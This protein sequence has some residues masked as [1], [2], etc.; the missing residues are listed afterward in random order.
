MR[1][2]WPIVPGAN[3]TFEAARSSAASEREIQSEGGFDIGQSGSLAGEP[4]DVPAGSPVASDVAAGVSPDAVPGSLDGDLD[5][6]PEP[7]SL[8][9]QP[10]PLKWTE[11]ATIALRIGLPH[12]GQPDGP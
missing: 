3:R 2:Q 8:R 11:A 5:D 9:A 4:P 6:S 1:A 10:D 7:R 12:S